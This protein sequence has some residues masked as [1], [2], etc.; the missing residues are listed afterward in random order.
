MQL[1]RTTRHAGYLFWVASEQA[2]GIGVTRFLLF[3]LAAFLIGENDF[4]AFITAFS[5]AA[6][7]GTTPSMGLS[8]GLLRHMADYPKEEHDRVCGTAMRMCH[9]AM[10]III[11]IGLV[12]MTVA[13]MIRITPAMVLGCLVPLSLS[14]YPE[15]QLALALSD[16]RV[17][18]EFRRRAMW[19]ML[20]AGCSV[21]GGLIG[22]LVGG[23]IGL[24]SGFAL[25]NA[26]AYVLL[27]RRRAAWMKEPHDPQIASVLKPVWLHL[28]IAGMLLFSGQ[29]LN[30]IILSAWCPFSEV[31]HLYGATSVMFLFLVPVSCC[32]Y[33]LLSM[34]AT[35]KSLADLS[36]QAKMQCAVLMIGTVVGL[37]I[38]MKIGGPLVLRVM[39]PEFASESAKLLDIVVW[40]VPSNALILLW[41][42]FVIKFYPVQVHPI[43]NAI[44][45]LA[46]LVPVLLLVPWFGSRGAAW[47]LVFG[48]GAQA[49]A[50]VVVPPIMKK[51]DTAPRVASETQ[52]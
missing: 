47:S 37:P 49:V 29:Y 3:P 26:V 31:S 35:Y 25:G 18:R 40:A 30:R 32:N 39:F 15:N 9:V 28:T 12:C 4:G 22:V 24:A 2:A 34:L 23:P 19:V 45:L 33:V 13:G 46:H 7:L 8:T 16:L 14:L 17:N 11:A 1:A 27:R 6:I 38:L 21:V 36:Y 43:V 42:P 48:Y 41:R 50:M 44:A 52:P 20:Q 10:L 51:R 5:V